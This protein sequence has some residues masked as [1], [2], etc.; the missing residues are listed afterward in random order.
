MDQEAILKTL[1][2]IE[3]QIK[4]LETAKE[5]LRGLLTTG[6]IGLKSIRK[7]RKGTHKDLIINILKESDSPLTTKE[8][9]KKVSAVKKKDVSATSVRI[10]L[11]REKKVFKK[12]DARHWALKE[13]E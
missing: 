11:N 4:K 1:S 5:V 13:K 12:T 7:P 3:G 8:I 6:G 10:V 9:S 2:E